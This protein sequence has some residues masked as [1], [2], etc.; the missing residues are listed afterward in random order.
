MKRF[1]AAAMC[2]GLCVGMG[3]GQA[4]AAAVSV[5]D[6]SKVSF[7]YSLSVDGKE[8]ESSKGQ[9]PLTITQGKGEIIPGLAKAIE[10]MKAGEEKTV[11][12]LPA[13]AYG[14]V[15]P[16][17][18]KEISRASLPATIQPKAGMFLEMRTP[19]GQRMPVKIAEVKKDTLV[20]DLNHPLAGKTLVF[21]IKI[22][23]VQ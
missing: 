3:L 6:G 10:G 16:K 18:F 22:V 1:A 14:N 9:G 23:S 21:K 2:F 7:D 19:N 5:K 15:D 17:A 11:T 13:E 4:R 20:L 8:A 12:V